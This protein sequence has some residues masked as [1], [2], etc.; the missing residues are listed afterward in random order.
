MKKGIH[1][2]RALTSKLENPARE[3]VVELYEAHWTPHWRGQS[4]PA[5]WHPVIVQYEPVCISNI[6]VRFFAS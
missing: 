6:P 1:I 4:P 5:E 3:V 2:I